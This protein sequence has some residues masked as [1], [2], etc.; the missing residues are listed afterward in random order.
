MVSFNFHYVVVL[1]AML[2]FVFGSI[3]SLKTECTDDC[4]DALACT[5]DSCNDNVC[6]NTI[7]DGN[8]LIDSECYQTGEFNEPAQCQVIAFL[9]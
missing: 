6:T 9:Y 2:Y 7:A 1:T 3:A 8:C 5:N 4:D